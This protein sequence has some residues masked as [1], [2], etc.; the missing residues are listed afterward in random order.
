ME[1]EQTRCGHDCRGEL[2]LNSSSREQN[3]DP[4]HRGE[5]QLGLMDGILV[6]AAGTVGDDGPMQVFA[7][8]CSTIDRL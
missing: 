3:P 1:T 2:H 5:D 6:S 8:L 7:G 4:G